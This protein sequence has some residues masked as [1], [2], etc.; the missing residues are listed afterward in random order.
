MYREEG[1]NL[2]D[3][4]SGE[5]VVKRTQRM[6]SEIESQT[7]QPTNTNVLTSNENQDAALVDISLPSVNPGEEISN[8]IVNLTGAILRNVNRG[9]E[10]EVGNYRQPAQLIQPQIIQPPGPRVIPNDTPVLLDEAGQT[11]PTS[12]QHTGTPH[13]SDAGTGW[14]QSITDGITYDQTAG[15]TGQEELPRTQNS[16]HTRAV[17]EVQGASSHPQSHNSNINMNNELPSQRQAEQL[18]VQLCK[19]NRGILMTLN[20]LTSKDPVNLGRM[21]VCLTNI[22]RSHRTYAKMSAQID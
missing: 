2:S 20:E 3:T 5:S 19:L 22:I 9:H 21:S 18:W 4:S 6:V 11:S 12:S 14:S 10:A 8:E 7:S 1:A 15:S 13:P 17:D 16:T